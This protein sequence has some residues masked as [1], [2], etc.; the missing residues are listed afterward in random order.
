MTNRFGGVVARRSLAWL[1]PIALALVAVSLVGSGTG[2]ARA[3]APAP[4]PP[5]GQPPANPEGERLYLRDCG[6]CHGQQGEGTPRGI[7][8]KEIGPAE[9]HY[10]MTTGYMPIQEPGDER[11]RREVLYSREEID[12]ILEHMRS[13][14]APEPEI[15]KVNVKEGDLHE[16]L[17]LFAAECA[18]CH[19]WA[20]VGGAL[21]GKEAPALR[22]SSPLQVAEAIRSG[23]TT[24]PEYGEDVM[25]EHQ[26]NSVVKY[27][28][29]L[30]HPEDRGGH[31][32]WHLGPFAEGLVGTVVGLGALLLIVNWIGERGLGEKP[33]D[34]EEEE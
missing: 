2:Q 21:L 26:L 8:L 3:Q 32:I 33:R 7:S 4:A 34:M 6:I 25:N 14:I 17:E 9:V 11:R 20:G 1:A 12:A 30:R 28:M 5:E 19:Q 18:S 23:P 13:F 24:M 22:D 10:S 15:P 29:Y 27:V 16:G 31:P